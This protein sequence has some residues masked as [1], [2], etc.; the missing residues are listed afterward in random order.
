M[1]MK[2]GR[3]YNGACPLLILPGFCYG[4]STRLDLGFTVDNTGSLR[5]GPHPGVGERVN[6]LRN[7]GCSHII[8]SARW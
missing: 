4:L 3:F 7:V 2:L 1:Q 8:V 6:H 5:C